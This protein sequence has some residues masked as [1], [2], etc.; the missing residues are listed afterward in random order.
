MVGVIGKVDRADGKRLLEVRRRFLVQRIRQSFAAER[1]IA[2]I[3][4]GRHAQLDLFLDRPIEIGEQHPAH[5]VDEAISHAMS[6][7]D[8]KAEARA[9]AV[10]PTRHRLPV[11]CAA[12]GERRDVNDRDAVH[13]AYSALHPVIER[14]EAP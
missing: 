3:A 9:G 14:P 10:D 12:F 8:K 7:D 4:V 2:A 5:V 11:L 1:D 6:G 13:F